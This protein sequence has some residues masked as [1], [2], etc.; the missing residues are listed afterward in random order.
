MEKSARG[1]ERSK[2]SALI[3]NDAEQNFGTEI[4]MK[5]QFLSDFV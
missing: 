4:F 3:P 2:Y 5:W 1:S